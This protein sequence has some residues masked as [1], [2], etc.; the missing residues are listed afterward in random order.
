[1]PKT[2]YNKNAIGLINESKITGHP[3]INDSNIPSIPEIEIEKIYNEYVNP[4]LIIGPY[5]LPPFCEFQRLINIIN[6]QLDIVNNKPTYK[7]NLYKG[8][9]D[10]LIRGRSIYFY[11]LQ[12][13][14]ENKILRT[15]ICELEQLVTQYSNEL[16]LCNSSPTGTFTLPGTTGMSL[17][18]PKNLIYA[19]AL[20]NINL[21]WYIYL[22]NTTKIEYNKYQG[23]IEYIKEKGNKNAYNEL[24][25]LLDEKF[26]DIEYINCNSNS[27]KD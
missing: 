23:V 24:I 12:L 15:K 10:V 6:T 27:D 14:N 5:N 22:Y 7:L 18:K 25:K 2:I 21:A 20:L 13:E 16:A 19:Q 1:M 9:L 17:N 8:I 3:L 4:Y 11:D 26:K